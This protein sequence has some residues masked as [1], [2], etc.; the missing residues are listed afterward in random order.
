VEPPEPQPATSASN[1]S[2]LAAI[3]LRMTPPL[4]VRS[5][6]RKAQFAYLGTVPTHH[7]RVRDRHFVVVTAGT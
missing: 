7:H 4:V 6:N 3:C 2:P 1:P 5:A